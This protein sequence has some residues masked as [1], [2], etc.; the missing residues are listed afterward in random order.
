MKKLW[1]YTR[2]AGLFGMV[3]ALEC[4]C[5]GVPLHPEPVDVPLRFGQPIGLAW[6]DPTGEVAINAG[7][8]QY[9]LYPS[10]TPLAIDH[11]SSVA[12]A[13]SRTS[14]TRAQL[15]TRAQDL[16]GWAAH[17]IDGGSAACPVP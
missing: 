8:M 4:G 2:F 16:T 11:Q 13:A 1:H 9:V 5:A 17:E 6:V 14:N 3:C 7:A 15:R 10:P 12:P